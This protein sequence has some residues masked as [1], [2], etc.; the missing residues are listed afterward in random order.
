M[1]LLL[2]LPHPHSPRIANINKLI[3]FICFEF[4]YEIIRK[5]N[6]AKKTM[7]LFSSHLSK[8]ISLS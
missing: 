6:S 2:L 5:V 3:F 7:V 1:P 8:N 4:K